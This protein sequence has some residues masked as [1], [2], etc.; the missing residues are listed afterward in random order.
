MDQSYVGGAYSS[1]ATAGGP[2]PVRARVTSELVGRWVVYRKGVQGRRF[3]QGYCGAPEGYL[4]NS[5][6]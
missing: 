3:V 4:D 2:P 1:E 6:G 5:D